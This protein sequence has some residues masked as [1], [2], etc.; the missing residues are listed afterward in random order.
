MVSAVLVIPLAMVN[1]IHF[2]D[3]D[4]YV[5][6]RQSDV[7][8]SL[9]DGYAIAALGVLVILARVARTAWPRLDWLFPWACVICGLLE[10][11]T[12]TGPGG[13]CGAEPSTVLFIGCSNLLIYHPGFPEGQE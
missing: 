9:G 1:W 7:V 13:C 6:G 2:G 4:L 11:A 3:S 12:P 5:S 10:S 8:F